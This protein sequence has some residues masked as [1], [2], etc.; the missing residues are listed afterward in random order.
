MVKALPLVFIFVVVVALLAIL[1]IFVLVLSH[2]WSF[3][4]DLWL[5]SAYVSIRFG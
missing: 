3:S 2:V 5:L 4:S 1:L